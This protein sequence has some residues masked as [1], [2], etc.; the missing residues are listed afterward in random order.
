MD[1][2]LRELLEKFVDDKITGEQLKAALKGRTPSKYEIIEIIHTHLSQM[3][4]LLEACSE[5]YKLSKSEER[6]ILELFGAVESAIEQFEALKKER[7]Q[8]KI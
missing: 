1:P 2:E 4:E 5:N 6:V 7:D 3:R 8:Q